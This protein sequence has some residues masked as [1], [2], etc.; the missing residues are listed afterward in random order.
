VRA[1]FNSPRG[2]GGKWV[3]VLIEKGGGEKETQEGFLS[4]PTEGETVVLHG[5][6]KG[7]KNE[8][9]KICPILLTGQGRGEKKRRLAEKGL[10]ERMK[11][12]GREGLIHLAGKGKDV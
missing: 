7:G 4:L 2:E 12:I 10:T 9:A 8:K 6:R 5:E 1:L 11:K 3:L